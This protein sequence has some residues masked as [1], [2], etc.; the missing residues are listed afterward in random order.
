MWSASVYLLLMTYKDFKWNAEKGERGW[1]D[2][3]YNWFMFGL[4]FSLLSHVG[5]VW[6]YVFML[7]GVVL[8]LRWFLLRFDVIGEADVQAFTWIFYGFGIIGLFKLAW[9]VFVFMVVY[10]VYS[11]LKL[12]V[13]KIRKSTPF[14]IVILISFVLNSLLFKLYI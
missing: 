14:F 7:L 4:T 9:F 1:V 12:Y 5:V 13:F 10:G 2:D 11:V 8:V 6:W 3:R